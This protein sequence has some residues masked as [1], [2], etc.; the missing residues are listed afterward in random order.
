MKR[1]KAVSRIEKDSPILLRIQSLK[2]DHPFW[3]YRRIWAYLRYRDGVVIGKNRVYRL[4]TEQQL[5]VSPNLTLKAKRYSTRPKPRAKIP[6]QYW[7]MDMT[8]IRLSGWGWIYLH[9]VLDW[10]TKEIIGYSLSATSKSSDWLDALHQAVNKRFPNGIHQKLGKPK[11]ITD[12]GCQPTSHSFMKNCA[13]LGI[14][15]IFTTW[16]NPKGN[17]DTERVFRTLKED[18]VWPRDWQLPFQFQLDLDTWILNYNTDFPHQS[19]AYKTPAQAFENFKN[20]KAKK[21]T[22]I[23]VLA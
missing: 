15:Q 17:A 11:L 23:V 16:N 7:G 3:G 4:M 6:N 19:L 22:K 14:K 5:L 10:S 9:V 13:T 2:A 18:L 20:R 21:E 12:N 8:K 1:Q